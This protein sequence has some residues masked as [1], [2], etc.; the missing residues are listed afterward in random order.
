MRIVADLSIVSVPL[1]A[2]RRWT[3]AQLFASAEGTWFDPSDLSTLF[4]DTAGVVPVTADG[5]PVGLMRDKSGNGHH[6][7][8]PSAALR[9]TWRTDGVRS[10]LEI[11]GV[12]DRMSAPGP[13]FAAPTLNA[14][15]G[16]VYEAIP[17]GRWGTLRTTVP[18]NLNGAGVSLSASNPSSTGAI[19]T[20]VGGSYFV[21]GAPAPT[22]RSAL[23]AALLAPA[24]LEGRGISTTAGFSGTEWRTFSH[25]GATAP[26]AGRLYGYVE[27]EG[28]AGAEL[29]LL[30]AWMANKVEVSL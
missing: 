15:A 27:Y 26:P 23:R 12:D 24:V 5:Q 8:Q 18:T 9:P 2:H 30:R 10:W 17:D 22:P 25:W 4:Q 29:D 28:A 14:M 7:A 13:V 20:G 3:P 11:D 19:Q 6:M 16:L 1:R 21:N